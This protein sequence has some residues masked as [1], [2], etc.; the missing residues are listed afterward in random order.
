MRHLRAVFANDRFAALAGVKLLRVS[1]GRARARM[2]IE[3]KN[4]NGLDTVQGGAIFTLADLTFA[5]AANSHGNAAVAI[6][7]SI[8]YFEAAREG[9][10]LTADAEEVALN[11]KLSS[12]TVRVTNREGRL[13]ALF[14]GMAYRKKQLLSEFVGPAKGRGAP[15]DVHRKAGSRKAPR[16]AKEKA[17]RG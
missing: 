10:V 15:S 7:V 1:E 14:T 11:P 9:D 6:N 4:L 13:V 8:S 2:R 17:S 16:R 12:C 5:A 3:A